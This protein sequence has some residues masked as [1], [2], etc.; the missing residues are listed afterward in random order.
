M[1]AKDLYPTEPF[2]C[3]GKAK[4]LRQKYYAKY[5]DA[6]QH[7][8]LRYMGGAETFDALVAGVDPQAALLTS[9]PYAASI[10]HDPR[11]SLECQEAVAAKGFALDM[12]S[13]MRNWWGSMYLNKYLFGGEFPR[14][15]FAF[16]T[17]VCC[18]HA[19]W[20]QLAAEYLN[21]PYFAIDMAVGDFAR[22]SSNRQRVDY[23]VNQCF[24]GIEF[25]EKVTGKKFNDEYFLTAL[26]N[27][28][29][30]TSL[31]SEICML[32][33]AIPAPMDQKSAYS[34]YVLNTLH[35]VVP[36]FTAFYRELKDEVEDRVKRG[37][38]A[39]HNERCRFV[40][41][42]QPPWSFLKFFRY[43]QKYGAVSVG[44][45]Y[46]FTLMGTWDWNGE[47]LTP[48][49]TPKQLGI[50]FKNREEA[51][52][53]YVEWNLTKKPILDVFQEGLHKAKIMASLVQ[54]WKCQGAI[55]HYNRG[56]EGSSLH[57]A[58]SRLYLVERGIPVMNY[59]ANMADDRETDPAAIL[60]RF[61]TFMESLGYKSL[62]N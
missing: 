36:E 45:L 57:V 15:D 38:A 31:W 35:R 10:A 50:S 7:G 11:F 37:I 25:L 48:A 56:C 29:E 9:E 53:F 27:E 8:R 23:V 1:S 24:E 28:C 13:Y 32:N 22:L 21:I 40:D 16:Q 19:K 12:C 41:D 59:E 52:R 46:S 44:S 58:E 62:Y 54:D 34:F 26:E 20:Y 60:V 14:P 43:M 6:H 51:V 17:H 47:H 3:W 49:K 42:S 33:Q 55:I 39:V 30:A 2:K 18:M 61:D 5:R 4:E